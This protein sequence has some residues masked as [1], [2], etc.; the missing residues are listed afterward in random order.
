VGFVCVAAISIAGAAAI[1]IAET[2]STLGNAGFVYVA[3]VSNRR[4]CH[5]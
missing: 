5:D 3:A 2:S 4:G 1:S